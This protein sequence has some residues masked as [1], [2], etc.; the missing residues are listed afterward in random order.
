[1][2]L[3]VKL[4][5]NSAFNNETHFFYCLLDLINEWEETIG[6]KEMEQN[7]CGFNYERLQELRTM[8]PKEV[9]VIGD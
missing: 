8:I 5:K 7:D 2:T 4:T 1:M 3:S 9:K 6:A